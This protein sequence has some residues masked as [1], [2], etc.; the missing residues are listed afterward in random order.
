LAL[1]YLAAVVW[2]VAVLALGGY[3]KL[4]NFGF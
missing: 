4:A 3:I 2:I 1:G